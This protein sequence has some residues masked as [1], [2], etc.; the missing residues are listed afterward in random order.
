MKKCGDCIIGSGQELYYDYGGEDFIFES[1]IINGSSNSRNWDV[2]SLFNFC[3]EC[4]NKN[5]LK[6]FQKFFK[7]PLESYLLSGKIL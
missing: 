6:R 3:P 5:N 4:G 2:L 7:E 1:S